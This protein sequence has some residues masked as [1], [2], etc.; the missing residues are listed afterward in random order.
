MSA[1]IVFTDLVAA[2]YSVVREAITGLMPD[3]SVQD[4]AA[5]LRLTDGDLQTLEAHAREEPV[6]SGP[7]SSAFLRAL[8]EE[9][10]SD[11]WFH[12][13]GDPNLVRTA[14]GTRPGGCLADT[15]FSLLFQKV[16]ARRAPAPECQV[17]LVQW[18]G[19][20]E[21]RLFQER[22]TSHPHTVS[23]E[24]ITY[25]DDHA[26]C[27]V[28]PS[29]LQL[30]Q[31]VRN[32]AGRTLDSVA[33]HGLAANLGPRKTAALMLHRGAGS[34]AARARTFGQL[35]GKLL[36]LRENSKPVTLDAVPQYR[37]LGTLLT[38]TGSL[39]PE[40]RS[41]L[42]LARVTLGEGRRKVFCCAQVLLERRVTLFQ[43][44]VMSAFLAGSGAWPQLGREAWHTFEHG[45]TAMYRQLLRIRPC[46]DQHWSR[47]AIFS[48][49]NA[50]TPEDSLAA[51]RLRFLGQLTRSGPDEA[52]ALLQHSPDV[53]AGFT[54]ALQWLSDAVRA[55]CELPAFDV[56]SSAWLDLARDRAKRW[57]G[58][59]KRGLQW[60]RGFRRSRVAFVSFC[61]EVWMPLAQ[62][63]D[64]LD[65]QTHACLVCSRAFAC[66]QSWASHAAL[67]HGYRN[68]AMRLARGCR[69][70]ACGTIFS[71]ARRMRQP[72]S[73]SP[74]CLQS[75]ERADATLLP[76]LELADGHVQSRAQPGR[77][78]GH[79]PVAVEDV[80]WELLRELRIRQL[81]E[82]TEILELVKTFVEP[83]PTLRNSLQKWASELRPSPQLD[84][85]SD[86]LLC[87]SP[88][89]LCEEAVAR[90]EPSADTVFCPDVRPLPWCPRPAG[91]AGLLMDFPESQ[92]LVATG[93][94]PGGGWR[95]FPF[96]RPPHS[97][98]DFACLA[99]RFPSSPLSCIS[100][101]KTD[102][103]SLRSQRQHHTWLCR[104]LD[105][106]RVAFRMASL[107]RRCILH[108]PFS[109]DTA[110]ELGEWLRSCTKVAQGTCAFTFRFT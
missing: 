10:H 31:A 106:L 47:D 27:V 94:L 50:P 80:C 55:T 54:G 62:N 23:V 3:A 4:I 49:C 88:F 15:V 77:G 74:R 48:A 33:G 60:H 18:S 13:N 34:K 20:R 39:L 97:S 57:K 110:G 82:D 24:D 76:V 21:L 37:H 102:S 11:T 108:F 51:E 81:C 101:W 46:D 2:Y 63:D 64:L 7:D 61:R 71:C 105:W 19:V 99:I 84:A 38:H 59:I 75:V 79:L 86:L 66:S 1:A 78:L 91:L 90:R 58:L 73:L 65:A 52:W 109:E 32:T 104:C 56:Q 35:K 26:S 83:L 42:A 36:V 100:L 70:Q 14:R 28:A 72:L 5:S 98:L 9:L 16:L 69:C 67:K 92:A 29:A 41:R 25:A 89:W 44:H 45:I 40:V 22:Q 53:I 12:L 68:K 30:E 6:L 87:F 17:P 43:A 107:G 85:V 8:T 103:C 96:D 93:A 95:R